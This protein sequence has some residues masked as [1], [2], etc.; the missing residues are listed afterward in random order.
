MSAGVKDTERRR[1]EAV[2]MTEGPLDV[3]R[4]VPLLGDEDWRVRKQAAEAASRA[5][6]A[7]EVR[8]A[9]VAG[10]LQPDDVGLR[11]AALEAFVSAPPIA[12]PT[13]YLTLREALDAARPTARKFVAA[14]LV[15][16]GADALDVL[17]SLSRDPDAMT[18]SAALEALASLARRGVDPYG[19]E[20]SFTR[21]LERSE[22][23]LQLSALDGLVAMDASVDVAIL[24][25]LLAAP[26]FRAPALR[27]LA[28]ARTASSDG[29]APD[30]VSLCLLA[31]LPG[32]SDPVEV[33]LV[34]A[35]RRESQLASASSATR[36][37]ETS[38]RVVAGLAALDDAT[39]A[40]LGEAIE[41]RPPSEARLL[42]RLALDAREHR[43]LPA[44]VRLGVRI[45]LD[46][47]SR[48][49]LAALGSPAIEALLDIARAQID[50]DALAAA[51]ALEAASGLL[52]FDERAPLEQ[53]ARWRARVVLIARQLLATGLER[54]A[55]VAC[56]ALGRWGDAEDAAL[57]ARHT[58]DH[59]EVYEDVAA[60][61]VEQLA[62]RYPSL[63]LASTPLRVGRRPL[64]S[65]TMR[66]VHDL[67]GALTSD[68]PMVRARAID[69]VR[70][71]AAED[72]L[73]LIT[74]ALTDGDERV[75]T[76]A[77]RALTRLRDPRLAASAIDAVIVA[78][79]SD[80]PAVR[81]EAVRSA[82]LLGAFARPDAASVLLAALSD[83][84]TQVVIA[85]LR[86]LR[87]AQPSPALD[88]A[89]DAMLAHPE[90]EV[91]KEAMGAL[92]GDRAVERALT[93]LE[94][95]H[96]SVRSRAAEV[97]GQS[98]SRTSALS[99]EWR[100]RARVGLTSRLAGE[101]D[102]LV[103][104]AIR[105]ALEGAG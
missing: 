67:R 10:L 51:W 83:P 4:L 84:S 40:K 65:Q 6:L 47:G 94:H 62:A 92:P 41:A 58:D 104:R 22:P 19:I 91:V 89:L 59:G 48:R 64:S 71:I 95:P 43:L 37:E 81:A 52:A 36:D 24:E 97:L 68:D 29:G 35:R 85:A 30:P 17:A 82:S 20:R 1:L 32:A 78:S 8:A 50:A 9:L 96:W 46:A 61:A 11:N 79:S 33:A 73:E 26:L 18:A 31:R 93:A 28:R 88:D 39:I 34:L 13:V 77:L 56:A 15:G 3:S 5:I 38:A 101:A 25:P 57:I 12:A 2:A 7:P 55:L 90:A 80:R 72:D 49:A 27:L 45:D 76:A 98:L 53:R 63:A 103:L 60:I 54:A 70:A 105:G 66:R 100:E 74:L 21:A 87:S 44:I 86:A 69:D 16:A 102:E 14:A 42:A 99:P 75:E 23:V